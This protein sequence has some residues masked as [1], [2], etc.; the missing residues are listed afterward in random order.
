MKSIKINRLISS[1]A[2]VLLIFG[3][4]FIVKAMEDSS[5]TI[6]TILE[7]QWFEFI[8]DSQ[9]SPT[10]PSNYR[11]I[12]ENEMLPVCSPG[13]NVCIIL[14]PLGP[15]DQPSINSSLAQDIEDAK[16]NNAHSNNVKVR[17]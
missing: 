16:T 15:N 5:S 11:L 12:E 8:G 13:P 17:L 6:E 10:D 14:A 4:F 7:D 3:A 9:D 2:A 1:L